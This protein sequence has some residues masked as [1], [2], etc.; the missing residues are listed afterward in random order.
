MNTPLQKSEWEQFEGK[1][2][3]DIMSALRGPD[4]RSLTLKWFATS[5]IR[6]KMQ[7]VIRVGGVVNEDL[8]FLILPTPNASGFGKFEV[9]HWRS[10]V[11]EAANWLGM[12]YYLSPANLF[13]D[14]DKLQTTT[15][16]LISFFETCKLAS[17]VED[18]KIHLKY[19]QSRG[20]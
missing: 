17:V 11:I 19:L 16:S 4:F 3:W 10:H 6:G 13:L 12:R 9:N 20:L 15:A 8:P 1:A 18:L 14:E 7:E 5:V 2:R